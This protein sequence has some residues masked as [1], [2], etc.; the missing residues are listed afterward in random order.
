MEDIYY[1]NQ[2]LFCKNNNLPLFANS[3][4]SH[5]YKWMSGKSKYGV[6]QSLGEMLVEVYGKEEAFKK[7]SDELITGC[8]ICGRTWCD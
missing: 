1:E 5:T 7:S 2:K 8:P 4:C 3:Y 6:R